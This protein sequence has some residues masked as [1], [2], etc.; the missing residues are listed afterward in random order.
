MEEKKKG[1][2]I[3]DSRGEDKEASTKKEAEKIIEP[4][5]TDNSETSQTQETSDE[6]SLPKIDFPT[7]IMSLASASIISMGKVPDPQTGKTVKNL[8]LAQQNI[9]IVSMLEEKTRG[10]L[11]DQEQDLIKNVLYELKLGFVDATKENNK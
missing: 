8:R 9:D 5:P 1:Y 10:N 7:L 2:T 6:K 3:K 4:K 11:T